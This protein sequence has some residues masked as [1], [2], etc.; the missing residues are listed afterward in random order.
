MSVMIEHDG[1]AKHQAGRRG[2]GILFAITYVFAALLTAQTLLGEVVLTD[3]QTTW[4]ADPEL[5]VIHPSARS[6]VRSLS[7]GR[8]NAQ[9]ITVLAGTKG[10]LETMYIGISSV[11]DADATFNLRIF[12]VSDPTASSL[13][14][15][16][17]RTHILESVLVTVE[18]SNAPTE[19]GSYIVRFDFT[20]EHRV[21]LG[22]LS[23]D[24]YYAIQFAHVSG[25]TAFS[26]GH[27]AGD[28]YPGGSAYWD[29]ITGG[30][31]GA[32]N[33]LALIIKAPPTG[34]LIIMR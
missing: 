2:R 10:I 17:S 32:D 31:V 9:T 3:Y 30:K 6:G 4:P 18:A 14:S 12:T 15:S 26:W 5:E 22:D 33:N 21:S 27:R 29:G 1:R 16:G 24:K 20:D 7:S 28:D 23:E 19:A 25:G 11:G 13:P 34:T 8:Y